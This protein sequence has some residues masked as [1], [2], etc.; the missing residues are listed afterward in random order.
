MKSME[1]NMAKLPVW[2]Q[3]GTVPLELFTEKGLYCECHRSSSV[4]GPNYSKEID[5][6]LC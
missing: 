3:L 6:I 5:V 2:I 4:Y 1:F